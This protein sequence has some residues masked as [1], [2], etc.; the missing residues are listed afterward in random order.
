MYSIKDLIGMLE[1]ENEYFG[2]AYNSTVEWLFNDVLVAQFAHDA[3][4]TGTLDADA[5][6]HRVD[7]VVIGFDGD[8]RAVARYA[9]HLLD[10]DQAVVDFRNLTSFK[11]C[12]V[13]CADFF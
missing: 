11:S 3:V 8:F 6:T 9:D 10:G 2:S 5:G 7:T 13:G 4:D 12:F 1:V